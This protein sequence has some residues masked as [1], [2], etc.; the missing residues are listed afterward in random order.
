MW[1]GQVPAFKEKYRLVVWDVR[2]H[3]RSEVTE[4]GYQIEQF[5]DDQYQLMR[6]LGIERAHIGGLSMGGWIAWSFALAH[7]EATASLILSDSAGY[8][9]DVDPKFLMT[10]LSEYLRSSRP[11]S[12]PRAAP[13]TSTSA[14]AS[15]P[16]GARPFP[17]RTTPCAAA[18]PPWGA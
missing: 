8:V 11:S 4:D 1:T 13:S 15:W 10:H 12:S 16:S 9:A 2:G 6:H 5:V 17:R 7:P 18:A 14:T 3:G